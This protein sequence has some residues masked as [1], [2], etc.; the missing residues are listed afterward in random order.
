MQKRRVHELAVSRLTLG[1][2]QLGLNYGIANRQGKPDEEKS[3]K[4]LEQAEKLGICAFD[5]AAQYGDSESV[6][7][8][9]FR[10]NESS[11][12]SVSASAAQERLIVTKFK[13][14]PDTEDSELALERDITSQLESSL[15]RL[16]LNKV[17]IYMVHQIQDLYRYQDKIVRILK[18]L[19]RDN[20]IGLAGASIYT[21][22]DIDTFMR[23][24]CFSATQIPVNI[25]DQR[26]IASGH[27]RRLQA[28]G[29]IVFARSVFLQ[30]LFFLDPEQVPANLTAAAPFLRQ[31]QALAEQEQIT[32]AQLAFSFVRDLPEITS[33]VIGAETPEQ[34][35]DN[36]R[37]S[38]GPGISD[39]G[40]V[41]AAG[42]F[43][44]MPELIINP[45]LW[46]R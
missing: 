30:G 17:A 26:L 45:F 39:P 14:H 25:F 40:R 8:R 16:G 4:I 22:D 43:A 13:I 31:L 32:V 7:G 12:S 18:R 21:G 36:V 42:H 1:T 20:L 34:V 44:Q 10:E 5:T 6:L 15:T 35:A 38:Q 24:D 28:A 11:S 29:L 41:Q 9:Y 27:L 46:N 2:V 37:L 3:R 33:L 19:I 23:Y